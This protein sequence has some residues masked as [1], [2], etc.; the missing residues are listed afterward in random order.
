MP[1][2]L[3]ACKMETPFS[4][5][6]DCPLIVMLHAHKAT[7]LETQGAEI[8]SDRYANNGIAVAGRNAD[9]TG[10]AQTLD[11]ERGFLSDRL[12]LLRMDTPGCI[13]GSLCIS[14]ARSSI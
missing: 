13:D 2:C 14:P 5:A 6:S 7:S 4:T 9:A 12:E 1:C 3:A 10:D 8:A 11:R